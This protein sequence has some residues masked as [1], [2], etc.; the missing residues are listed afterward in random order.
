MTT[1]ETVQNKDQNPLKKFYRAPKLYVNLPSGGRFNDI[2]EKAANG[3]IPVFAM[4]AK[5]ELIMRNPDALLNGDAV[6]KVIKSCAPD[7]MD[8]RNLPVCDVDIL[9]IAI[10]M[11]THGST[12]QT[13]LK[14]PHSGKE[15]EYDINLESIIEDVK[16]LPE[17]SS[18][19]LKNGCTV[20]V[21]PFSYTI[22]TRLN[23]MAY[24][25][26]KALRNVTDINSESAKQFTTLFTQLADTNMDVLIESIDKIST[27]EGVVV[28]DKKQIREFMNSI[29]SADHNKVDN[30][31][32]SLNKES[33]TVIK[34]FK[35]KETGSE[36]ESTVRLDPS[37]FF[38]ST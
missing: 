28:S 38:V 37:D 8:V 18:V 13:K 3:E 6:M 11:A 20:Y 35:C 9:L 32:E 36:F 2:G 34:K 29:E 14:S 24:D 17:S 10:R 19:V 22:Q 7:I 33:T 12:L 5:D 31:I 16:P 27:P 21:K 15:D 4:T 30:M 26:S 23:L 25:Q 1:E